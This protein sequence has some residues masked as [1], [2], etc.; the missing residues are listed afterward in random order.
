MG[1]SIM[2]REDYIILFVFGLMMLIGA[3]NIDK[4]MVV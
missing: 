3:L 2:T 1:A 4:M